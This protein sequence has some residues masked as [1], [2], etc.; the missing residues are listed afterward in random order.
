M[1]ATHGYV[2]LPQPI[3]TEAH[4]LL[5]KRG[6]ET[7]LAKD[8]K[9]ETVAPLLGEA[10]AVVLRTGIRFTRELL[11]NA[12][13]LLHI[14][15][16]GAGVDNVDLAAATERGVI[17][18]SSVGVNTASVVE[19]A[20]ALM[21]AL[22]K[23]LPLMD[24]ETRRNNFGIRYRNYPKDVKGKCLGVVGFG[25]IGAAFADLCHKS[26]RMR[27]VA[28]DPY[29]DESSKAR[30]GTWAQFVSLEEV[31]RQA[32]VVSVHIPL[33]GET[34]GLV[35]IECLRLM[36]P[37][38]FLINASRGG[39]VREPDLVR[40]L[41]E[42]LL[43]G[44]GLDVFEKEPPDSENPLLRM[45]NVILTPHTAALTEECVLEMAVKAVERVVDLMDG[46]LPENVAN[47][48]VLTQERWKELKAR[49]G[50]GKYHGH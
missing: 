19:H 25:R 16:T 48:E 2:L 40:A 38:G 21:F 32:D 41:E 37:G 44:A 18:T 20:V 3:E 36:R 7:V 47:P 1:Q 10:S 35:D 23:Q 50:T 13:R 15:R 39:V 43:A 49:S 26:F 33:T 42:K 27:V 22:F 11:A 46:H 31:F 24:R 8:P 29:L 17:V 28:H 12:G 34:E 6:I 45:E 4:D 14:S 9:P 30:A 5:K